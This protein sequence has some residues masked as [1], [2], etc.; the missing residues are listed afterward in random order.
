M[1]EDDQPWKLQID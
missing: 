1:S